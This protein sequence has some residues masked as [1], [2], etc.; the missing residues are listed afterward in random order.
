MLLFSFSKSQ[1]Q[2]TV[3]SQPN[4]ATK[5]LYPDTNHHTNIQSIV[6][7]ILHTVYCTFM[8]LELLHWT[9]R[10]RLNLIFVHLKEEPPSNL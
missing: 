1:P 2:A 6:Y 5:Q 8:W 9:F 4:H 3:M 7:C 10:D